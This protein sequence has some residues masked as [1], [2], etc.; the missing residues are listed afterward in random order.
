MLSNAHKNLEPPIKNGISYLINGQ[1]Q[2]YHY[3]CDGYSD[4]VFIYKI[5][6]TVCLINRQLNFS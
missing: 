1:Y 6:L 2:Y 3:K 5:Y 4:T